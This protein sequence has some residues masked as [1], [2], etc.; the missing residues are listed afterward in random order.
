MRY[1][2]SLYSFVSHNSFFLVFV[3]KLPN[4]IILADSR[5]QGKGRIEQSQEY[6]QE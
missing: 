1:H 6:N 4:F 2:V 3:H 5:D